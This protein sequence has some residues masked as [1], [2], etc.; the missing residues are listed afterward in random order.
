MPS[1]ISEESAHRA[2]WQEWPRMGKK[3]SKHAFCQD[4]SLILFPLKSFGG[5]IPPKNASQ[6]RAQFSY[7]HTGISLT[8]AWGRAEEVSPLT[9]LNLCLHELQEPSDP[10]LPGDIM[11]SSKSL[12][13][14]KRIPKRFGHITNNIPTYIQGVYPGAHSQQ[15]IYLYY[16]DQEFVLQHKCLWWLILY[17]NLTGP[18][19]A[20]IFH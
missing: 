12:H 1:S 4:F 16:Q 18:W 11:R 10:T 13:N 8:K 19:T 6:F 5:K 3:P 20:Q 17:V 9:L 7:S 15:S 14:V 2:S